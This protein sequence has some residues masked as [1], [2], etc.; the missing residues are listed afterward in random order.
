MS[1]FEVELSLFSIAALLLLIEISLQEALNK[2][3]AIIRFLG[4]QKSFITFY[5]LDTMKDKLSFSAVF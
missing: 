1:S 4:S 5:F 2:W 3:F